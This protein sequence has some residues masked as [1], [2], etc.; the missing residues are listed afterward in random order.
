MSSLN[1]SFS[2]FFDG[3][4]QTILSD[5][6]KTAYEGCQKSFDGLFD[7]LNTHVSEAAVSLNQTPESW[8]ASAY[9]VVSSLSRT[10]FL[11]V[12]AVFL[13]VVFA[14]E[15]VQIVQ[16]TNQSMQQFKPD[17]IVFPLIKL[18]MCLLACS[19]AFEIIM[20][21]FKIGQMV[22]HK[23]TSTTIGNFGEGLEFTNLVPPELEHYELGD[24][25]TVVG[26][27]SLLVIASAATWVIGIVIYIRVIFW[28]LE[29]YVMSCAAPVPY[30]MWTNKEWQQVSVNYTRKMLST[31]FQGPL[32]L[33]LYAIYGGVMEGLPLGSDFVGSLG[34]IIG[35]AFALWGMLFKTSS[36]ADS[37]FGAH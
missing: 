31:M 16:N 32:M 17:N 7:S 26:Y 13:A 36:I 24:V 3:L 18:T 2:E 33:M 29:I 11:P 12:A 19:H 34:M 5:L 30:A 23:I 21:F 28:F 20:L 25:M 35:S 15:L 4:M 27:S 14:W 22:T 37:I 8:N 9:G 1:S 6:Y 10:A